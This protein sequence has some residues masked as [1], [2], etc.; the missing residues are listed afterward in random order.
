M[1]IG[2]LSAMADLAPGLLEDF[3]PARGEAIALLNENALD[4]LGSLAV[5]D[6]VALLDTMDVAGHSISRR[7]ARTRSPAP[8]GRGQPTV[9]RDPRDA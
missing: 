8:R 2:D 6:A 9:P 4:R 5:D 3:E 7:S 1:G